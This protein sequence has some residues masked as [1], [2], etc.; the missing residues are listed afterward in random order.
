MSSDWLSGIKDTVQLQQLALPGTHDTASYTTANASI[1]PFTWAQRKTFIEQLDLGVRVLDMRVGF[2]DY[3][4][5]R[6]TMVHGPIDVGSYIKRDLPK[7]LAEIR[8]WLDNHPKEFV[9]LIF[10]QQG[11]NISGS[12]CAKD[13]EKDYNRIVGGGGGTDRRYRFDPT[14]RTWPTVGDLRGKIMVME[15]LKSRIQGWADV[16]GWPDAPEGATVSVG[17]HLKIYLQ[18]KYKDVSG[19]GVM[20][21][22]V[23]A[24]VKKK[25]EYVEAASTGAPSDTSAAVQRNFLTINH[26]SYSNKRHQPYTTGEKVNTLLRKSKIRIMGFM[27]IDDADEDTVNHILSFNARHGG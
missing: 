7:A 10:Q 16:S 23:E 25:L 2:G 8:N 24:E 18:D 20:S 22:T 3:T 4:G 14:K 5:R 1:P 17:N 6:V 11:I 21:Y 27:M 13:V 19:L 9:V 15:R 12:D 26:T